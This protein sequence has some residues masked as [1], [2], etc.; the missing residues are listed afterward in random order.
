MTTY[1]DLTNGQWF[2]EEV[3]P[4]LFGGNLLFDRDRPDGTFSTVMDHLGAT[5]VRYPG[6]SITEWYFDLRNPDATRVWDPDRDEFR[7]LLPLSDF[8]TWAGENA[9]PVTLAVPTGTLMTGPAGDRHPEATA[10]ADI[11]A[12]VLDVL[13][14][15]YGDA[16]IEAIELGNE[17][18]LGAELNV[19][20][21]ARIADLM[22]RAVQDAID[23]F[24]DQE[25]TPA[26]WVEPDIVVQVGQYGAFSQTPG[27]QQNQYLM[28]AL[29]DEA[30]AA[31][32][33][34]VM[35][36]YTRGTFEDLP[37]HAYYFDRLDD[38]AE[39]DRFEG[40]EYYMT[41]WAPDFQLSEERG[42]RQAST[43]IWMISEMVARG[44][45]HAHVWPV[46]QNTQ[47]D[48]AGDEG[49][50]D[51]TLAGEGFRLMAESVQGKTL[52]RRLQFDGGFGYLYRGDDETVVV[53]TSRA[54]NAQ[55]ITLDVAA[56][57]LS[58][59]SH[60]TTLIGTSGAPNDPDA[61]PEMTISADLGLAT[62]E[63]SFRLDSYGLLRVTFGTDGPDAFAGT[64]G[65]DRLD[66]GGMNETLD[67]RNGND[68]ILAGGGA[69]TVLGGGGD[70]TLLGG[71]GADLILAGEGQDSVRGGDG[72]DFVD[73]GAGDD[74]FEDSSQTGTSGADKVF[75]GPGDDYI[76]GRGGDDGLSGDDGDDTIY[77]GSGG[78]SLQGLNGKDQ[79]IGGSGADDID[80][81]AGD[82][83]LLGG[84]G[85]DRISGS[86]GSDRLDGSA[87]RDTLHGD[88]GDDTLVGDANA[89]ILTGGAGADVLRGGS[90]DDTL[91][92]GDGNDTL[93]GDEGSDTFIFDR[94]D[95]LDVIVSFSEGDVIDLRGQGLSFDEIALSR[96]GSDT[97]IRFAGTVVLIE[98]AERPLSQE[99]FLFF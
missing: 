50:T 44:V 3:A 92:G 80:G 37:S 42:L 99:D 65:A 97:I 1:V 28:G 63:M 36:Y 59:Q 89:D 98:D 57:G 88:S 2:G 86:A 17:Y 95:G 14:G 74:Q 51:L 48:L 7:D 81:G 54:D 15:R 67:G 73:L 24:A 19:V 64:V 91:A 90:G 25:S 27:W 72:A 85:A 76:V 38:W 87:G 93:R 4:T 35:H 21:Y 16:T 69:D 60:W 83:W 56:L 18:W 12:F 33:G 29:S 96:Q 8:L 5:G 84:R 26:G 22:A 62:A 9:R 43:M 13:N 66:G 6:G 70:D 39:E 34:V 79:L 11:K 45:E 10:Y 55:T 78:D 20:E 68:S 77:G 75:G 82:D 52:D 61:S 58:G 49:E 71:S 41:E 31:I 23:T 30:A 94:D 46:Q 53:L 40:I 47:N 32:D